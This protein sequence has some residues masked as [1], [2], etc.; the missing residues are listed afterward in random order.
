[1]ASQ[2]EAVISLLHNGAPSVTCMQNGLAAEYQKA[3]MKE[4]VSNHNP[5]LIRSFVE[6]G[7]SGGTS[8]QLSV[9][10]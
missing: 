5:P 4:P 8:L 1:M 10:E 3:Q 2:N 6:V 7:E 9:S